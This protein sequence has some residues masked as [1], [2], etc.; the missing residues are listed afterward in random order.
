MVRV[1]KLDAADRR[2]SER[3]PSFI[4]AELNGQPITILDA[5]LGG[6]GG[7]IELRGD[8]S[9]MP[10]PG[11]M[12]TVVLQTDSDQ[13]IVLTVEVIRVDRDLNLFGAQIVEM[14]EDQYQLMKRLCVKQSA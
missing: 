1:T 2:R 6:V 7:T 9:S 8:L 10:E 13:P 4:K 11:E 5:S 12:A 3:F 14:S